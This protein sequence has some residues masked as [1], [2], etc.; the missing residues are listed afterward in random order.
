LRPALP[1]SGRLLTS[2]EVCVMWTSARSVCS[3]TADALTSV[4]STT[5][6]RSSFAST[7]STALLVSCAFFWLTGRN[8][9]DSIVT[10]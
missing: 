3:T 1:V 7:R 4:D 2:R 8:P 10:L 5:V 6:D 9:A